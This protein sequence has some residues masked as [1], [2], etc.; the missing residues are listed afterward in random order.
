MRQL[1]ATVLICLASFAAAAQQAAPSLAVNA[2]A[3]RHPI[4]P[5]VYGINEWPTYNQSTR[6]WTDS[7]R[8]EAMRGGVR[9]W[10][11]DNA[12]SYNWQLDIKNNDADWYFTTYMVGDGVTSTFDLFHER[13]LQTG[14]AS[15]GTV[16]VLDWTPKPP[17]AGTALQPNAV[18]SCSFNVAKYGAQKAVD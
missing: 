1:L 8:S 2:S 5:Y 9:R 12:T 3:S 4:S 10:G 14:T 13:N 18:L 17:P 7:G 11:G 6:T 15:L 16:P